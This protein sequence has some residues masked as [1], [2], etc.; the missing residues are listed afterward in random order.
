MTTSFHKLSRSP[1]ETSTTSTIMS[2]MSSVSSRDCQSNNP[3]NT[4][5]YKAGKCPH[6]YIHSWLPHSPQCPRKKWRWF[7]IALAPICQRVLY[8]KKW[9]TYWRMR[10]KKGLELCGPSFCRL[11]I[12]FLMFTRKANFV[13]VSYLWKVE[14]RGLLWLSRCFITY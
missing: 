3:K 2:D 8:R 14:K 13:V 10:N 6:C 12:G 5:P 9:W 11:C 1:S 7:E 4:D